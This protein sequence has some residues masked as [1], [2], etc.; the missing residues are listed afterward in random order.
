MGEPRFDG[1]ILFLT[2]LEIK[3]EIM[4]GELS[5]FSQ[6]V[7]PG[8]GAIGGMLVPAAIY[9]WLS[10]GDTVALDGWAIPV[11]NRYRVCTSFTRIFE[12]RVPFALKAFS[13]TLAILEDLTA[14]I[15]IAL[16]YSR[17]LSLTSLL[18]AA[19]ALIIG[20]VMNLMGVIRVSSYVLLGIILWVAMLKS[21]VHAALAGAWIVQCLVS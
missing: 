1:H 19:V 5:L 16:F 20:I 9:A 15:I 13:L 17:D 14:I 11:A 8:M 7:L 6:V 21:Y 10:R 12:S 18:V 3:R 4:E 2:G